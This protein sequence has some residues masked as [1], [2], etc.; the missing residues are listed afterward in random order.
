MYRP[1]FVWYSH[2]GRFEKRTREQ[3]AASEH[4]QRRQYGPRR[5]M[6]VIELDGMT[7]LVA[8][9]RLVMRV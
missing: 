7:V 9:H 8:R 4:E 6:H 3:R 1:P 2:K 5:F